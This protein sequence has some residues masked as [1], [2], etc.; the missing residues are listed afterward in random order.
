MKATKGT[1]T[2]GA[3]SPS[4]KAV[5]SAL[6]VYRNDQTPTNAARRT[7]AVFDLASGL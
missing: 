1:A 7:A 3:L 2:T 4:Q 6:N 5:E